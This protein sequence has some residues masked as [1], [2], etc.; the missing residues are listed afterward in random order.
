MDLDYM[1]Y[2][3]KYD[4]VHG[5]YPGTIEKAEGAWFGKA[6]LLFDCSLAL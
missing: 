6:V 1:I 2:Q 5:K 3:L 4:S